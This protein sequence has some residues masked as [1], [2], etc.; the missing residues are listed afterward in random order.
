MAVVGEQ[1]GDGVSRE[2]GALA[3]VEPQRLV[4]REQVV[5]PAVGDEQRGGGAGGLGDVVGGAGTR[6]QVERPLGGGGVLPVT[7]LPAGG[8]GHPVRAGGALVPPTPLG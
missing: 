8:S 5:R 7:R 4:G 1:E 3:V 2:L 6:D